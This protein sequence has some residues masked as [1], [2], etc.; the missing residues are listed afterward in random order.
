MTNLSIL[1]D[2]TLFVEVARTANFTA[3]QLEDAVKEAYSRF[4]EEQALR[5]LRTPEFEASLRAAL[6]ARTG[7]PSRVLV[8]QSARPGLT[9]VV[10]QS[11]ASLGYEPHVLTHTRFEPSFQSVFEANQ[12][13]TFSES[14]NFDSTAMAERLE[15]LVTETE[16]TAVVVPY[17]NATG[18]NYEQVH[19]VAAAAT[20]GPIVGVTV[21][22]DVIAVGMG[23]AS[24]KPVYAVA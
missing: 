24:P 16:F 8:T 12:I 5:R 6:P 2:M 14:Y 10:M 3:E 19:G 4:W 7:A 13:H 1:H 18:A 11:L 17:H 22:G 20:E 21:R 9:R 23:Q 15:Q